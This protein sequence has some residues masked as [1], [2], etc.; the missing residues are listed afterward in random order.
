MLIIRR[1]Q[2]ALLAE[3]QWGEFR[4]RLA[5]HLR[6]LD[7]GN[8]HS[9]EEL[10][11]LAGQILEK[12]GTLGADTEREIALVAEI[13]FYAGVHFDDPPERAWVGRLLAQNWL[14][15]YDKLIL[16]HR[17]LT[18]DASFDPAAAPSTGPRV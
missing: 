16:I 7:S 2:W 18:P 1:G 8:Q 11:Q 14:A 13:A 3:R 4:Q 10:E 6:T 17:K 12:A 5:A 15:I 9:D